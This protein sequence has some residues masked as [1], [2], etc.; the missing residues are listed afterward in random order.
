MDWGLRQSS[1]LRGGDLWDLQRMGAEG[2][3]DCCGSSAAVL[4][5]KLLD[6]IWGNRERTGLREFTWSFGRY[7][8]WISRWD[9]LK[10]DGDIRTES[11]EGG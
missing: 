2:Q 9:L 10:L 4:G 1:E 8:L 11:G 6:W 5:M 3:E 7:V